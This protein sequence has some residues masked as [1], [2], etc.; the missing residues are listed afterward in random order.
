MASSVA[1]FRHVRRV[2]LVIYHLV[3][4]VVAVIQ[5]RLGTG[6]L[7]K[8]IEA[9]LGSFK[10]WAV[11]T[12]SDLKERE[13]RWVAFSGFEKQKGIIACKTYVRYVGVEYG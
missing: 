1:S 3:V 11:S 12:C 10:K 6:W 8:L 13:L 5:P 7:V 2:L 4:V 9:I